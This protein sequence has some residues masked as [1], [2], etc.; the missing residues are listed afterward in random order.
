MNVPPVAAHAGA[1]RFWFGVPCSG[2][3]W[4]VSSLQRFKPKAQGLKRRFRHALVGQRSSLYRSAVQERYRS[5]KQIAVRLDV[6]PPD[7]TR[8]KTAVG[9]SHGEMAQRENPG[10]ASPD[11]AAHRGAF[12]C[13]GARGLTPC[14]A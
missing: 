4:R 2:I 6:W 9:R 13:D 5:A 1:R 3:D 12:D 14:R 11:A 7:V 10:C 8:C